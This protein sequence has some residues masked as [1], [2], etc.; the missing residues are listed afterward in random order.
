MPKL[1]ITPDALAELKS[2]IHHVIPTYEVWAFGS[3]LKQQSH[4]GSDLDL[5]IRNPAQLNQPCAQLLLFKRALE[6]S[7][8]PFLIDVLDWANIPD[9]FREEILSAY[10][11]ISPTK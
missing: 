10:A 5:V 7:N 8:I 6:E 11:V 3:R 4:S 1:D 9:P 2:V